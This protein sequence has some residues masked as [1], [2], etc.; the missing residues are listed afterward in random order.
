MITTVTHP[1]ADSYVSQA[2][3]ATY[4]TGRSEKAQW[5]ALSTDQK[6]RLLVR[7]TTHIDTQ[8]Y[9]GQKLIQYDGNYRLRQA[10]QFPRTPHVYLYGSV[11]SV[12]SGTKVIVDSMVDRPQYAKDMF[13]LGSMSIVEGTGRG[14]IYD[15][16]ASTTGGEVTTSST[17]T[18]IDTTSRVMIFAPIS[19]RV[20]MAVM[21]QAVAI[22]NGIV[23]RAFMQ[24]L[25]VKSY[26]I[27]DLSETY[28]GANGADAADGSGV[29]LSPETKGLLSGLISRI[30]RLV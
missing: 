8:R 19:V 22:M 21:E 26:T 12:V 15:I 10:L 23:D 13:K 28:G 3:M 5:D 7:A 1:L 9:F 14:D 29:I 16:T 25:G 18:S 4:L 2:E 20:K 17:I 30:G 24:A 6:D 11:T 27:G